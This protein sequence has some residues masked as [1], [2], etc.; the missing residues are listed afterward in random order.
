MDGLRKLAVQVLTL[1]AA[2]FAFS[3]APVEAQGRR[4]APLDVVQIKV[5]SLSELDQQVRVAPDGYITLP[6]VESM[7]IAGM[8]EGQAAK[9][10]GSKLIGAKV[11]TDPRVSVNVITSGT[12]VVVTGA[13]RNPGAVTLERPTTL[14]EAISRAGGLIQ[15]GGNILLRRQRG[16][17]LHVVTIDS[18][19]LLDGRV[20][21][22]YVQRGDEIVVEEPAV[23]FLYGYVNRPG[24]YPLSRPLT[25][26][27]ALASAGGLSE[28]GSESRIEI[29]RRRKDGTFVIEPGDL[30]APV[31][32]NDTIIVKERWF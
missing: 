17:D 19:S 25:L 15:P 9:A 31:R 8:T 4:I 23:Y 18:K 2:L 29:K 10:I 32:P 1:A 7:R 30:D 12:Q 24:A 3:P 20:V 22:P 5:F 28:L 6:Y 27:Q 26:Q 13:V 16:R 11:I 14:L 21:N